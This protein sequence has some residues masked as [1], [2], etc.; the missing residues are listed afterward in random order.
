MKS[1][2]LSEDGWE[3]EDIEGHARTHPGTFT[4]PPIAA[5]TSIQPGAVVK[6]AFRLLVDG[7]TD[8]P[9][10]AMERMWVKVTKSYSTYYEGVLDNDAR[11][12]EY[13]VA[14]AEI[15]FEPRHIIQ[16]WSDDVGERFG[17]KI[18]ES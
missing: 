11:Y 1:A 2:S 17:L 18:H 4:P 5:R 12:S 15:V 7:D 14:G 9:Q 16:I 10:E 8:H 6:L 3:L 13:M